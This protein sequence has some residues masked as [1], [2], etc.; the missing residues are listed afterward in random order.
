MQNDPSAHG[1]TVH[2]GS[3]FGLSVKVSMTDI[4]HD[5]VKDKIVFTAVA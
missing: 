1:Q 4:Q 5:Y 3:R 2:T